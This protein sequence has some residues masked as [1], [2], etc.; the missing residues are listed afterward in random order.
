MLANPSCS[1]LC[2]RVFI[3]YLATYIGTDKC[4]LNSR[5]W[6]KNHIFHSC[7]SE[8]E[9]KL[10]KLST[11]SYFSNYTQLHK[12]DFIIQSKLKKKK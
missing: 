8:R 9:K 10:N 7:R 11:K 2:K 6:L 12:Q 5:F 3:F 4:Y 1:S